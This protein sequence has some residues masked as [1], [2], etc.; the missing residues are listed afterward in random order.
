MWATGVGTQVWWDSPVGGTQLGT[1][2]PFGI[3]I[4]N[5]DT[6]YVETNVGTLCNVGEEDN[7]IGSTSTFTSTTA[8]WGLVFNTSQPIYLDRVHIYVGNVGGN[9]TVNLRDAV[10]G[11]L[12]QSSIF[13]VPANVA[14][15]PLDLGW[16]IP[17]GTGFAL[18]LAANPTVD[19]IY[20]F[21]GSG[22]PISTPGC[23][24]TIA[25]YFNPNFNTLDDYLYFYDWEISDGCKTNR[26]PAIATVLPLPP[27]PSI[28]Q[29]ANTLSSVDPAIGYQWYLNGL[30][31]AGATS[32]TYVVTALGDYQVEVFGANGCGDISNIYTVTIISPPGFEESAE[33]IKLQVFPNPVVNTVN[34]SFELD[35]TSNV[36][37]TLS[38]ALGE[39]VIVFDKTKVRGLFEQKIDLSQYT[40]GI[41]L[42]QIK[43]DDNSFN[44]KIILAR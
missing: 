7:S 3:N 13:P 14:K 6:F 34:V 20:N 31:I 38:N 29:N 9:I 25:G 21:T 44:R 40:D 4:Q 17:N 42:L 10:G 16:F 19:L 30:P 22:Y 37:I 15:F 23:P 27:K 28:M 8:N 5:S 24:V 43:L 1:G 39:D 26:F 41:Y 11:N 36:L 2:S 35:E 32:Q 12:L 18:E 33:A